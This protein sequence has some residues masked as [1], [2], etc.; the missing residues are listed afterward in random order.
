MGIRHNYFITGDL[1]KGEQ[2]LASWLAKTNLSHELAFMR[3]FLEELDEFHFDL[4]SHNLEVDHVIFEIGFKPK[5]DFK[6]LPSGTIFIDTTDYRIIHEEFYFEKN[7]FPLLLKGIR[8]VSRHWDRLPT[9]EWVFTRVLA[10]VEMRGFM[11]YIP[12]RM[13]LSLERRDFAF[14]KPYSTHLFGER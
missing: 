8:H 14:D 11:K 4:R 10:E 9:G 1:G 7:P 3:N 12:D 13:Q 6:P 5:S 2:R